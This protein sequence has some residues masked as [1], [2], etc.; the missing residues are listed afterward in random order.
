MEFFHTPLFGDVEKPSWQSSYKAYISSWSQGEP[1]IS[2]KAMY[3]V[4]L[5]NLY[6]KLGVQSR[7]EAIALA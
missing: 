7:A 6:G 2:S 4:E 5:T 1:V 3:K